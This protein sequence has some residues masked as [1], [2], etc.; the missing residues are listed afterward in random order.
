MENEVEGAEC[1]DVE[2]EQGD[3]LGRNVDDVD[4]DLAKLRFY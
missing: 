4:D 3:Y 2:E 1:S